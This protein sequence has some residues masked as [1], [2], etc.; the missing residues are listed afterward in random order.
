MA[1]AVSAE[2]LLLSDTGLCDLEKK[3]TEVSAKKK[4]MSDM[5]SKSELWTFLKVESFIKKLIVMILNTIH[6]D[7]IKI[8]VVYATNSYFPS[9]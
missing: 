2:A 9:L 6:L 3:S 4:T 8:V 7:I 5:L 1:F